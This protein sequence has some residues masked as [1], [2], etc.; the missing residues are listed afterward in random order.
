MRA[1]ADRP[2]GCGVEPQKGRV[3]G[4]TAWRPSAPSPR[5]TALRLPI[6]CRLLVGRPVRVCCCPR[7]PGICC[8]KLVGLCGWCWGDGSGCFL[9]SLN[10]VSVYPVAGCRMGRRARGPA[11]RDVPGRWAWLWRSPRGAG[12]GGDP[13][14]GTRLSG[15]RRVR[16]GRQWLRGLL[17][18]QGKER[19]LVVMTVAVSPGHPARREPGKVPDT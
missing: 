19:V 5:G 3:A 7:V 18:A 15:L 10:P 2:P 6:A 1:P 11:W 14:S 13:I 16:G 8:C 17:A 9:C 12:L 4:S